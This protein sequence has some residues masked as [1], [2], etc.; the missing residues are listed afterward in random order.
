MVKKESAKD[1]EKYNKTWMGNLGYIIGIF[2]SGFALGFLI[3]FIA[4]SGVQNLGLNILVNLILLS[5]LAGI[6]LCTIQQIKNPQ[7]IGKIG[8]IINILISA[9]MIILLVFGFYAL[10]KIGASI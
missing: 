8:L 3:A 4:L 10:S 5:P 6:V 2:A 1:K 9:F 7:K